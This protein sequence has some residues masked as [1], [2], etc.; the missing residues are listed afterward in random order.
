MAQHLDFV[1]VYD[2]LLKG[3]VTE[4]VTVLKHGKAC[5]ILL[6]PELFAA[7]RGKKQALQ[8]HE[9][10]PDDIEAI[11]EAEIPDELKQYNHEV[12]KK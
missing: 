11:M 8:A 7:M 12:E 6:P 4:P 1:D 10:S 5:A 2:F 3:E 9:L